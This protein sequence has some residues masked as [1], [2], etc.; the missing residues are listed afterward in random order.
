MKRIVIGTFN[1]CMNVIRKSEHLKDAGYD[2]Y[3]LH[4]TTDNKLSPIRDTCY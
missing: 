4:E 3:D 2:Y 1:Q